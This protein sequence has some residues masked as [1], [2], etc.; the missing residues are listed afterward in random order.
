M[1]GLPGGGGDSFGTPTSER[2]GGAAQNMA[3]SS[4]EG[5]SREER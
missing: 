2:F 3:N 1:P 4:Y 5:S